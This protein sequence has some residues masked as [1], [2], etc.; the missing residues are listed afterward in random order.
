MSDELTDAEEKEILTIAKK[1]HNDLS[2]LVELRNKDPEILL[3]GYMLGVA[4]FHQGFDDATVEDFTEIAEEAA[5]EAE[6][7]TGEDA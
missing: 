5:A 1:V 6:N 4:L 7:Q 2:S 3:R